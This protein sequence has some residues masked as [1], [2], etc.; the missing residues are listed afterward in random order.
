MSFKK[1]EDA[2]LQAYHST[3]YYLV[4]DWNF[5]AF[6]SVLD[7]DL[8]KPLACEP[9]FMLP[10]SLSSPSPATCSSQRYV[11]QCLRHGSPLTVKRNRGT[12]WK[13]SL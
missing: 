11:I 9:L 10:L 3:L 1:K 12:S 13:R 2:E 8:Y 5:L 6:S 4:P 7:T